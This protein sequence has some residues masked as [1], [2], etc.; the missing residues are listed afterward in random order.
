[1]RKNPPRVLI[2]SH[3]PLS[4]TQNNGKTLTS[5]FAGW[6]REKLAQLYFLDDQPGFDICGRFFQCTDAQMLRAMLTG[7]PAGSAVREAP[8]KPEQAP[9][10]NSL[11]NSGNAHGGMPRA[12]LSAL[13][14]VLN[15][16][17]PLPEYGRDLLWRSGRWRSPALV[18]WLDAFSPEAVFFQGSNYPFA[19]DIA[20]W[21][22][23]RYG[24]KLLIQ[25]TDDYT[26]VTH[27]LLPMAWVFRRRYLKKF[28]AG[29]ARA[30][31]V[32]AIGPAMQ[33]EYARRFGCDHIRV[34]ANC[35]TLQDIAP[36]P[37]EKTPLRLLYAGSLHTGRWRV[38]REIGR[39]LLL[40]REEG[41]EAT[42]EIYTPRPLPDGL[43]KKLT[44]EPAMAV[45]GSLTPQ[46]LAQEMGKANVLVM[47]ES[48]KPG[49]RKVTRLSL[50]TKIPEYMAAGRCILAV[51][52]ADISSMAYL[53]QRN[54]AILVDR[55]HRKELLQGLRAAFDAQRR[56]AN[57]QNGLD[58]VQKYHRQEALQEMIYG[59]IMKLDK[60]SAQELP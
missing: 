1:M 40:L 43:R 46:Q 54:A 47:V 58:A 28:K 31:A 13:R 26:Y 59:D 55:P 24:I 18:E 23:Q 57:A 51:G 38:L 21:I 9:P 53:R 12:M 11:R 17:Y 16:H 33:A 3:S 2:L 20:Q 48:F 50:S 35:V 56:A 42:L 49:A 19:Y 14:W 29:L 39:A 44:L 10:S 45:C 41:Q 37:K 15:R 32:Y 7:A 34:A 5:L 27:P 6:P 30:Q 8:V 22:C 4:G 60:A 52:P 36:E 25:L